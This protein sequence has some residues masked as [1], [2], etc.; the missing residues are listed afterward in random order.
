MCWGIVVRCQIPKVLV[1]YS[2]SDDGVIRL[3]IYNA[4]RIAKFVSH[5]TCLVRVNCLTRPE[6]RFSIE[7]ELINQVSIGDH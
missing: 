7:K 4:K 5:K 2:L 3:Q 6:L 1:S